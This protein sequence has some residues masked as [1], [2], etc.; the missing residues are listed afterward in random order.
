M[1]GAAGEEDVEPFVPDGPAA[2]FDATA[3]GS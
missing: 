1:F 3:G 2:H